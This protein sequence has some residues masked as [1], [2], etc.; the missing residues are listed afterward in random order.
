MTIQ[1]T[2]WYVAGGG[3]VPPQ[4]EPGDGVGSIVQPAVSLSDPTGLVTVTVKV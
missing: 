4:G 1:T 3:S 2:C